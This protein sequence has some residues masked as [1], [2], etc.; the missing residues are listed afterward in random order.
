[1]AQHDSD[2]VF[3]GWRGRPA[4]RRDVVVGS[5]VDVDTVDCSVLLAERPTDRSLRERLFSSR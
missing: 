2:V 3:M 1:M 5:V 4:R